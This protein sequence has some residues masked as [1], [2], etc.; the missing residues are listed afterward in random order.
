M[1]GEGD[2]GARVGCRAVRQGRR[3]PGITEREECWR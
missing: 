1:R 3:T 2:A